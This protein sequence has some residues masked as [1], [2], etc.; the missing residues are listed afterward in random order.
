VVVRP[1]K[2]PESAQSKA[3][4]AEGGGSTLYDAGI[5]SVTHQRPQGTG[6]LRAER[7]SRCHRHRDWRRPSKRPSQ[8]PPVTRAS[9]ATVSLPARTQGNK[10][11]YSSSRV[12]LGHTDFGFAI[13]HHGPVRSVVCWGKLG[14]TNDAGSVIVSLRASA[15]AFSSAKAAQHG[16]ASRPRRWRQRL[17]VSSSTE[18]GRPPPPHPDSGQQRFAHYKD[19][20]T[21]PAMG[22][23]VQFLHESEANFPHPSYI[24]GYHG[25]RAGG[26]KPGGTVAGLSIYVTQYQ[27]DARAI[28]FGWTG[29]L[30]HDM[31]AAR[32]TRL[33]TYNSL[34]QCH[35]VQ[36]ESG[37]I[38]PVYE[39]AA[40]CSATR[41]RRG[42]PE[43]A[44]ATQVVK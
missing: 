39:T 17:S 13:V 4:V 34:S 15:L 25:T 3:M 23:S 19:S 24:Y 35:G 30:G 2:I 26:I 32:R 37:T 42:Q 12:N 5:G 9:D 41:P 28:C 40:N 33:F 1:A 16:L 38:S 31:T 43:P 36:P 29:R 11:Q 18:H 14:S 6:T 27:Y 44:R 22:G 21:R 7:Y 8:L 10:R 20:G